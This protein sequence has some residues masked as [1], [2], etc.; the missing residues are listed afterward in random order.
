MSNRVERF[1][2]LGVSEGLDPVPEVGTMLVLE[3]DHRSVVERLEGER[4]ACADE[5]DRLNAM[6]QDANRRAD[7]ATALIH[8]AIE[9]FEKR[10]REQEQLVTEGGLPNQIERHEAAQGAFEASAELLRNQLASP[11]EHQAEGRE[12]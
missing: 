9:E 8:K 7:Q 12:R 11:P 1:E 5:A 10:A 2:W 3:S 4:D 6:A